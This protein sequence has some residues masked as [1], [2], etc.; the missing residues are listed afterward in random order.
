MKGKMRIDPRLLLAA[1]VAALLSTA[2]T[3]A[4]D[5]KPGEGAQTRAWV[6]LQKS[7]A[8]KAP[9]RGLPG[10]VADRVYQRYLQ[11]FTR[12]IPER[13]ERDRAGSGDSQR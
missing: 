1:T 4:Q 13:F 12:P 8:N 11:S 6:E 5:P 3:A 2:A 10:E 7:D 9:V